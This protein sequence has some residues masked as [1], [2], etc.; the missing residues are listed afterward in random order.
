MGVFKKS[1]HSK[2][3][4][5]ETTPTKGNPNPKNF[6]IIE[7]KKINNYTVLRVHYPGCTNYEGSKILV[8]RDTKDHDFLLELD[9]HFF[10]HSKLIAR[11]VPTAEGWDMAIKF[12]TSLNE[13]I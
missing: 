12:I 2:D 9:P 1:C 8:F 10:R 6:N 3:N 11:F 7:S 4:L 5:F 13:S